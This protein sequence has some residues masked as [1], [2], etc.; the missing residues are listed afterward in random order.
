MASSAPST[1]PGRQRAPTGPSSSRGTPST[2]TRRISTDGERLAGGRGTQAIDGV[3][4]DISVTTKAFL[5]LSIFLVATAYSLDSLVR[6]STY[7]PTATSYLQEHGS[8][9]LIT[10]LEGVIGAVVQLAGAKLANVVGRLTMIGFLLVFYLYGTVIQAV[11]TN[12][13]LYCTGTVIYTVGYIGMILV[14]EVII[15]DITTVR[16]RAFFAYVPIVPFLFNTWLSGN[17]AEIT[18][19]RIGWRWGTGIWAPIYAVCTIPLILTLYIGQGRANRRANVTQRYSIFKQMGPKRSLRALFWFIDVPGLF[20]LVAALGLTLAPLSYAHGDG[21]SWSDYRVLVPF[22]CGIFSIPCFILWEIIAPLPIFPY[23]L[24]KDRGVWGALGIA[25]TFNAAYH[26]QWPFLTTVLRASY[27][28]SILSASRIAN[29]YSFAS[30]ITGPFIGLLI[31]KTGHLKP[32]IILGTVLYLAGFALMIY[33]NGGTGNNHHHGITAA[34]V[35]LGVAGGMFP[36]PTLASIQA[37]TDPKDVA[38]VTGLFLAMYRIGATIGTCIAGALWHNVMRYEIEKYMDPPDPLLMHL[39]FTQPFESFDS[40]AHI[41]SDT[42]IVVDRAYRHAQRYIVIVGAALC[43]PLIAF[44]FVLRNPKLG[45]D[46]ESTQPT[47]SE[48]GQNG[49]TAHQLQ[50]IS[51]PRQSTTSISGPR[52]PIRPTGTLSRQNDTPEIDAITPLPPI[53]LQNMNQ[54]ASTTPKR[55]PRIRFQL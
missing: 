22:S 49:T 27:H 6:W 11:A 8:T 3:N 52:T 35:L 13:P 14:L 28:Q 10:T 18:L 2:H 12:I 42:R 44:A 19:E 43:L 36:F 50:T 39:V 24:L 16:S 26:L 41:G 17:V 23:K 53:E 20:L 15:V 33:F 38:V 1:G 31:Y 30:A 46:M 45:G 5:F 55:T 48:T 25:L 51:P 4:A 9:A 54:T 47:E 34:Q 21:G 37:V 7:L 40:F 32:F 29:M